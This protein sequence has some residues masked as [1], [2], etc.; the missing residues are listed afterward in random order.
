LYQIK[1]QAIN[2]DRLK[3][4]QRQNLPNI[5]KTR[6]CSLLRNRR[7]NAQLFP[8]SPPIPLSSELR[9]CISNLPHCLAESESSLY[10]KTAIAHLYFDRLDLCNSILDARL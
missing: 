2:N 4:I 1:D 6:E 8:I 7:L 5:M 3:K 9:K 10:S